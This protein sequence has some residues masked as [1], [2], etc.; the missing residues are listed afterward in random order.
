MRKI[1][2][3]NTPPNGLP[4]RYL[5]VSKAEKDFGFRAGTDFKEGLKKTIGWYLAQRG[6]KPE[7][8]GR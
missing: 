8:E 3:K 5:D 7:S 4:R 1:S 6:G 2:F